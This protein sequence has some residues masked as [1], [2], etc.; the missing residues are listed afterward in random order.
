MSSY[1]KATVELAL[2]ARDRALACLEQ[3]C[4]ERDPWVVLLKT[5]RLLE[6]LRG[7]PR[8]EALVARVSHG[9]T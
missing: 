3:A 2:G 6:P 9:R 5:D 4:E 1:Q 7:E 8:Y